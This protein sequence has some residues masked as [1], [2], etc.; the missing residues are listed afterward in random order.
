MSYS[1]AWE[2]IHKKGPQT[3][4]AKEL[5]RPIQPPSQSLLRWQAALDRLPT[6]Q[7]LFS[8][9]LIQNTTCLLCSTG[10]ENVEHLFLLCS[11]SAYIWEKEVSWEAPKE[12]WLKLN[13][14]G[15]RSDDRFSYGVLVRDSSSFCFEALSTRVWADSIN[16]LELKGLVEGM[17][18]CHSLRASRVWLESDSTTA[19]AWIHGRGIIPWRAF[20][21]LRTFSTLSNSL[22]EWKATHVYREGN[23][24]ADHLAAFQSAMGYQ[25][26]EPPDFW[27]DLL[28]LLM[29]DKDGK[30]TT[31][32]SK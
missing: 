31:R 18:L 8:R 2:Y 1:S 6:L 25:I 4:W 30:V 19:I 27:P 29:K 5:W 11:F 10:S 7:R 28:K 21:D 12:G 26:H 32:I 9:Q 20:R 24:V 14:D 22:L 23:Q 13:S 15:S 16:L 3:T 17:Q